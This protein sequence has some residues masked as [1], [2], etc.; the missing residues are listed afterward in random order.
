MYHI[1]WI[2]R[3]PFL[4]NRGVW[5]VKHLNLE[6]GASSR[7]NVYTPR[8]RNVPLS[9]RSDLTAGSPN[10]CGYFW[11]R[12]IF[13][14]FSSK[15]TRPN[16]AYSILFC[17]S[18]WKRGNDGHTIAHLSGHSLYDVWHHRIQKPS[19]TS[20]HT[21]TINRR[22]QK[23]HSGDRSRTHVFGTRKRRLRMDGK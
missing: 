16:V 23:L 12:R 10:V 2:K 21:K 7:E 15:N 11:K 5:D 4:F 20:V 14:R 9:N 3:V 22:L 8:Q 6:G 1:L 17:P 19:F 13:F 18:T